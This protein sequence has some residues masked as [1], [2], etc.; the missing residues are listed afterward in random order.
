MKMSSSKSQ[1][2]ATS[3][4]CRRAPTKTEI[5]IP[6][7]PFDFSATSSLLNDPSI[8]ELAEQIAKD[9][10]FNKMVEQLHQSVLLEN[11]ANPAHKEQLEDHRHTFGKIQ[12]CSPFESIVGRSL[13]WKGGAFSG[14]ISA[15]MLNNLNILWV[16]LGHSERRL[17]LK[18]GNEF[19]ANI[20]ACALG[21]GLKMI[22]CVG[23]SLEQ[24]EAR[25]ISAQ[26]K[27]IAEK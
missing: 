19:V 7:N 12:H 18:E 10:S 11:I 13:Q 26:T 25:D 9:P 6:T 1:T 16:I 8:K 3:S 22:A 24:R 4:G 21:Q 15:K 2:I 27:V 5:G 23:E 14:E 17:L 20:V